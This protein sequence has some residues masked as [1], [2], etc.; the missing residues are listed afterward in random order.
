MTLST[1]VGLTESVI[2]IVYS[3]AMGMGMARLPMVA[4][5]VERKTQRALLTLPLMH[6]FLDWYYPY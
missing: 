3:M 6:F 1:A 5:R 2:A 4:R